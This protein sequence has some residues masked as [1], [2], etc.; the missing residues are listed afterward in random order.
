MSQPLQD[1]MRTVMVVA[2]IL[3]SCGPLK[4]IHHFLC[5]SQPAQI[6]KEYE[7]LN[8]NSHIEYK[9]EN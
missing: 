2:L 7:G 8:I 9:E 1:E 4:A 5:A 6:S 3:A